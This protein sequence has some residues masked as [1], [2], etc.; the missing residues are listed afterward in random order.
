MAVSKQ[1]R[2]N[3]KKS[4]KAKKLFKKHKKKLNILKHVK[5][6]FRVLVARSLFNAKSRKNKPSKKK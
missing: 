1:K 3:P 2:T 4:T 5:K 6:Q